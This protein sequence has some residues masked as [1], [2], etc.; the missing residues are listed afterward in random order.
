MKIVTH[1][2]FHKSNIKKNSLEAI[3]KSILEGIAFETDVRIDSNLNLVL[4]HDI[5]DKDN[6]IRLSS[7]LDYALFYKFFRLTWYLQ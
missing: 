4:A 7:I 1:R 6:D 5:T 3:Q 2:G